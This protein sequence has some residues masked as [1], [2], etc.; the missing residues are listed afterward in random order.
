MQFFAEGLRETADG[1]V[2]TAKRLVALF[3]ADRSRIEGLRGGTGSALRVH[4][5][6]RHSPLTSAKRLSAATGISIPTI[7]SALTALEQL[8]IARETTGRKRNRLFSY[9]EYLRLL[10]D[11]RD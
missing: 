7:N 10:G 5:A 8:G 4:D 11:E 9:A 3:E 2:S 1:A 6:L